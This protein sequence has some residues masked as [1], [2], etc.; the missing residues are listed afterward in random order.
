MPFVM[1]LQTVRMIVLLLVGPY[2][3]RWIASTLEP[4]APNFEPAA[5]LDQGD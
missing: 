2:I 4:P 3:A 5:P 1:A